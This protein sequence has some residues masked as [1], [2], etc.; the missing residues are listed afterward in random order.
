[1]VHHIAFQLM[2]GT[3][4]QYFHKLPHIVIPSLLWFGLSMLW[5]LHNDT[6]QA[7]LG[8]CCSGNIWLCISVKMKKIRKTKPLFARLKEYIE[9]INRARVLLHLNKKAG[10][11]SSY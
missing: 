7:V 5:Y 6:M 2:T 8:K 10:H 1:M 9:P 11:S 4:G 3:M